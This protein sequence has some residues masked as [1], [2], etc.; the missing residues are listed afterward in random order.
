MYF[1]K[2]SKFDP[3]IK[4]F[5]VFLYT[6]L[7]FVINKLILAS[8]L[9]VSI[10]LFRLVLKMSFLKGK[11]LFAWAS[12]S[13]FMILT[14]MI[15][16]EVK[17]D[18]LIKG[19]II[20]CRIGSIMLLL[21]ILTHT[22]SYSQIAGG[23][24]SFINYRAVFVIT[25]AFNLIPVFEAEGRNIIDA[26]KLRGA[27]VFEKKGVFRKIMAYPSL[28]LPFVLGAMRKALVSSAAMDS[29]GFG[30]Y[31]TRTWLDKNIMK[32]QDYFF[33]VLGLSVF[34]VIIVLNY[35]EWELKCPRLLF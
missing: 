27:D 35:M 29:K 20:C 26:Q 25:T 18:G 10:I 3:R 31:K 11:S 4:I 21:P 23:L 22:T 15:F 8:V 16:T 5:L 6:I 13:V 1:I 33:L 30:I 17:M 14:K 34:A 7:V 32:P 9:F 2:V 24:S 28:V 12:L 19:L